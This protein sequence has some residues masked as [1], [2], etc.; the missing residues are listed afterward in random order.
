MA[1]DEPS[2]LIDTSVLVNFQ[3]QYGDSENA[4][5]TLIKE[6]KAGR[7]KTVRHVWDELKCKFPEIH[8]RV[9]DHRKDFVI[10][11]ATLYSEEAVAELQQVQQHHGKLINELGNGNPADPF[12]IAAAKA[13]SVIVVTDEKA[14]GH[15]HRHCIPFVCK[16]RNVGCM[17]GKDYLNGLGF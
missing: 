7:L 2:H 3:A 8:K 11:D 17:S 1:T 4:W 15:G 12:L 5:P 13:M 10:P 6:I 14:S 9:K 16:S